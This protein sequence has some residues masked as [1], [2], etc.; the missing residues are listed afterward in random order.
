MTHHD[1]DRITGA[2]GQLEKIFC[3]PLRGPMLALGH[4]KGC[5]PEQSREELRGFAD[6]AAEI[7]SSTQTGFYF[8]RAITLDGDQYCP[9]SSLRRELLTVALGCLGYSTQ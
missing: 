9:Q 8:R 1:C 5:Q 7:H 2:L 3:Q 4:V 6:P